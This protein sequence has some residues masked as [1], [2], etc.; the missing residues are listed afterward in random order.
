MTRP[1]ITIVLARAI[2][3]VIGRDNDLPW[4]IPGDLKR[5]KA[6]T[7]GSAMIMGRKTFDSL[8]GI[9][10][11]RR[12]IVM[13]RDADWSHE[14]VGV[15]HEVDGAIA[16]A[17]D[18]PISVIGGAAIFALFEPIADR[19]ELTEVLETVEGDVSMPDLRSSERWHEVASEDHLATG[20]TPSWRT[21]S[22]VRA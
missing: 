4:H 13:T 17:G 10:P 2:N 16:L 11:G 14:G 21:V 18:T 12:H 1:P 22:L 9:L 15:A 3:G 7:M 19:I 8:P 5:F 20:D 6:L